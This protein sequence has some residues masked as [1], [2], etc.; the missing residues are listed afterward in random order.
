MVIV[1]SHSQYTTGKGILRDFLLLEAA[2]DS[3]HGEGDETSGDDAGGTYDEGFFH[4]RRR[5]SESGVSVVDRLRP[6]CSALFTSPETA[7]PALV[8]P[9]R[10]SAC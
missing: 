7:E 5:G 3:P 4:K 10:A 2:E 8:K 1:L 6:R 9:F